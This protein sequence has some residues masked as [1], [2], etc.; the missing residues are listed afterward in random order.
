MKVFDWAEPT[1][2]ILHHRPTW[3]CEDIARFRSALKKTGQVVIMVA[4]KNEADFNF[5]KILHTIETALDK[6]GF[7]RGGE[8]V[9]VL[10]PNITHV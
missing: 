8:Y 9:I 1:A 5:V 2:M 6:E 10:T 4:E 7:T 3:H